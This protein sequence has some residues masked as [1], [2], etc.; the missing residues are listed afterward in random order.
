V[1]LYS[2]AS[3]PHTRGKL[4]ARH[5][6]SFGAGQFLRKAGLMKSS[7]TGGGVATELHSVTTSK[8]ACPAK[9]SFPY[10]QPSQVTGSMRSK[11]K[12]V[13]GTKGH[14]LLL[15]LEKASGTLNIELSWQ[16]RRTRKPAPVAKQALLYLQPR[17][18]TTLVVVLLH[19]FCGLVRGQ[20]SGSIGPPPKICCA[21][22]V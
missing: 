18:L 19:S 20:S 5:R 7:P 2:Q 13:G 9:H 22:L 1:L 8:P 4:L 14:S 12:S 15:E 17:Q 10:S 11:Q 3:G 6:F 21:R 16:S